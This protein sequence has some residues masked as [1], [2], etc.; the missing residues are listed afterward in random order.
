[1]GERGC[2]NGK[3]E[4]ER[5]P[6]TGPR[7]CPRNLA[8][9]STNTG[10]HRWSIK[11]VEQLRLSLPRLHRLVPRRRERKKEKGGA[12]TTN[13]GSR[14]GCPMPSTGE[15]KPSVLPLARC[16]LERWIVPGQVNGEW[17]CAS[18]NSLM[19]SATR[20]MRQLCSLFVDGE[21]DKIT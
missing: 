8:L 19:R 4:R 5:D 6:A 14:R 18:G 20:R 16:S 15:E 3:P 17:A 11:V 10:S 9:Y 21:G 1:M 7:H 12:I 2:E 13:H